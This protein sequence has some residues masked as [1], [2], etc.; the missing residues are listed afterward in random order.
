MKTLCLLACLFFQDAQKD[1]NPEIAEQLSALTE[2]YKKKDDDGAI[3]L[4]DQLTQKV[5][6]A[7]PKDRAKIGKTLSESFH[8]T[9][10]DPKYKL[11]RAAAAS[12]STLGEDGAKHLIVACSD[13]VFRKTEEGLPELRADL[14]K[15]TGRTKSPKAVE[16]LLDLLKDKDY[17]VIAGAADALGQYKKSEEAIRKKIVE[18]LTKLL[19]TTENDHM[20]DANNAQAQQKYDTIGGPILATLQALTGQNFR[21]SKDW[22]KWWNDQ[23]KL[24]WKAPS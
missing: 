5:Q 18:R 3:K 10:L 17:I 8:Q 9:R 13:R 19:E 23:K 11:I 22:T 24:P 4:I 7:G 6:Q 21:E 16:P 1:D 2:S 12:L 14:A 20:A 15:A